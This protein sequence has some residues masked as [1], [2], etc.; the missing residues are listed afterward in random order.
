ML[1]INGLKGLLDTA[2]AAFFLRR[3]WAKAGDASSDR[4][5]GQYRDAL[6]EMIRAKRAGKESE[7][8]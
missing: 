2:R 6:S 3:G 8:A 7:A 5:R 1:E 4:E